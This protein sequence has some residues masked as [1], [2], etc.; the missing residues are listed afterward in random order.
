M[1]TPITAAE[2]KEK[3]ASKK[4]ICLLDVRRRAD[5]DQ[6]P[7]TIAGA[8]WHDPE[9]VAEWARTL[10]ADQDLVVYCVRGGSVSQSVAK[11]L[12]ESHPNVRF[13]EGGII[14]WQDAGK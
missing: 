14:G 5:Y 13:L 2:L 8:T 9:Q 12:Q 3:L 10:P 6:S 7:E 1:T 11:T 4:D